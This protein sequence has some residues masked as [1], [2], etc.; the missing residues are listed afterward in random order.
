MTLM[1]ELHHLSALLQTEKQSRQLKTSTAQ[2][3]Q[4]REDFINVLILQL[5]F[6]KTI[7]LSDD[8]TLNAYVCLRK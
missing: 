5:V 4:S 6:Q 8:L 7:Y 3:T 2:V 1:A